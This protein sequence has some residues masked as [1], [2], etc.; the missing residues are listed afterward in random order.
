[1]LKVYSETITHKTD[2]G[3]V[4]L[5]LADEDAVRRAYAEIDTA[6]R[7]KAGAGQFQGVSV[8]PMVRLD[9]YELIIGSSIDP[10]FGPVVLFGSGGQLV[11]VY[12]DRALALPP[13]NTT[14]AQR[15]I[16][17]TKIYRALQGVRGRAAVD[18]ENLRLILVRFAKLLVEQPWIK[19][20]DINPL[21]AS[22]ERIV[23]LDARVILHS[24]EV[25]AENL[26]RPAI[27]PYPV[28]YVCRWTMKS[29]EA[30]TIRP[31]RPEDEPLMAKFHGTLSDRSVYLRYFHMERLSSR[32]AHERLIQKCFIDYDRELALVADFENPRTGQHEIL[33]VG[34]LTK[35]PGEED[36][37][38][39]VLISDPYQG[40]GIGTELV[41]RLIEA[42]RNEKLQ[43][44]VANIL[45]ENAGMRSLADK[46]GFQ[47]RPAE[48]PSMVVAVLDLPNA[49]DD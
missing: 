46:F 18:L 8:Q 42:G 1:V 15:L 34:R 36:A 30:V 22:E 20:I 39:G 21:L 13:L 4:K 28:K 45:P 25:A 40:Q 33:G 23:A 10:Q 44:I 6:V 29:G 35:M 5:N 43:H 38:V 37:E 16:E 32:V 26:P 24:P 47:I 11:E 31:I 49:A 41:R 9:G 19:E 12:G 48:D 2:V 27:Q 14:L 7:E 17:Q 3:G